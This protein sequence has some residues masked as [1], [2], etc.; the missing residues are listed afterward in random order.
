MYA[1]FAPLAGGLLTLM[2]ILNSVLAVRV[3]NY[4][5]LIV[6]HSVGLVA[7]CLILLIRKERGSGAKLPFYYYGGGFVG[8]GTVLACNVAYAKLDASLAVSLALLGQLI[9]SIVVDTTGLLG[10]KKYP[11]S[12]RSL[13]GIVL[14]LVGIIIISGPWAGKISF[15][16]LALI[17]GLLPSVSFTMNSQLGVAKG[18][19]RSAWM[20]YA[21]GLVT[22]LVLIAIVRPPLAQGVAGLGG[23]GLLYIVGG[24]LLG[25][26][27]VVATN[28]IFPK[29]PALWSTL[30]MFTGQALTG[31]IVDAIAQGSF[32]GRKLA[33][34]LIVLSGMGVNAALDRKKV[35][36]RMGKRTA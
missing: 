24:G 4:V 30:L 10:R 32:S 3:G 12:A 14:A 28:F 33:G 2:N 6:I 25:V 13:P 21:L 35:I 15:M 20:N 18:I 16:A 11:L 22:T 17:S 5:S 26:V 27:M 8:V 7:L 34:T 36:R 9:G 1:L 23:T 29:I 31:V 19:F